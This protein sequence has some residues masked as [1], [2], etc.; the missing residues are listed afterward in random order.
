MIALTIVMIPIVNAIEKRKESAEIIETS[1]KK[2]MQK[3]KLN[4]SSTDIGYIKFQGY[5]TSQVW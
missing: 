4:M 2:E 5:L 1:A 3:G